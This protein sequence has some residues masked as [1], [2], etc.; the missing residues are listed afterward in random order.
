MYLLKKE[1]YTYTKLTKLLIYN[2]LTYVCKP[3]LPTCHL[4]NFMK[5][6]LKIIANSI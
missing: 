2:S 3:V 4:H 1:R 5:H 6:S